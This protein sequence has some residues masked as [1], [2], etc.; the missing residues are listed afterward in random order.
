MIVPRYVP[1]EWVAAVSDGA[2]VLLPAET[3]AATVE[4]VWMSLREDDGLGD[5]LQVL[6]RDGLGSLPPFA[7]VS[8]AAGRVQ[9]VVRGAVAVEVETT[10]GVRVL[11]GAEVTTWSEATVLEARAVTVR[12]VTGDDAD[13]AELPVLSGVVRASSVRV[14]LRSQAQPG[15]APSFRADVPAQEQ[16]V[17]QPVQPPIQ[18]AVTAPRRSRTSR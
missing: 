9:A 12:A 1:G 4:R 18:P 14:G 13:G 3:S 7:L 8:L 16:P 6:L 2:I 5:H 11:S 10:D 15:V 17:Q